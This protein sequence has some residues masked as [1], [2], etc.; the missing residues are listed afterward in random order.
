MTDKNVATSI[1][2]AMDLLKSSADDEDEVIEEEEIEEDVEKAVELDLV[3]AEDDAELAQLIQADDFMIS[4][5]QNQDLNTGRIVKALEGNMNATYTILDLLK[6]QDEKIER[7]SSEV[8]ELRSAPQPGKAAMTK[9]EADDLS[10]DVVENPS[11][12]HK[13]EPASFNKS[14]IVGVLNEAV[15]AGQADVKDVMK[16]ESAFGGAMSMQ[17]IPFEEVLPAFTPGG[18]KAI[19]D[20]LNSIKS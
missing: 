12:I 8:A 15:K 13:S 10:K 17:E 4:L 2:Q 11:D 3:K 20:Y 6:S 1:D 16:A 5:A 7:L 14:D 19:Q 9:G 18:R